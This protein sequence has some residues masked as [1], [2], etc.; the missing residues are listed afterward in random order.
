MR[1]PR[2]LKAAIFQALKNEMLDEINSFSE[3]DLREHL[4]LIEDLILDEP[5]S[6]LVMMSRIMENQEVFREIS[7]Y[8]AK[9]A[10]PAEVEEVKANVLAYYDYVSQTLEKQSMVQPSTE[11]FEFPNHA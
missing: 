6:Q 9:R 10:A 1:M 2:E 3:A 8:I 7:D 4:G 11:V 5:H